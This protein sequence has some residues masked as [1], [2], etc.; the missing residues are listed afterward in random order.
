M[1]YLSALSGIEYDQHI[2]EIFAQVIGEHPIGALVKLNDK[3][4]GFVVNTP[5][6]GEDRFR[7]QIALVSNRNGE[8]FDKQPLIDL[9]LEQDLS[10]IDDL[11]PA[12]AFN[13][14]AFKR[15]S[16]LKVVA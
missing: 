9:K 12:N 5:E 8:E 10:I 11:D 7:P 15:F 14:N 2:F 1:R 16:E 3:S 13:Q 4:I 6:F